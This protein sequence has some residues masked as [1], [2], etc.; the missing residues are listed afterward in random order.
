[1]EIMPFPPY[2]ATFRSRDLPLPVLFSRMHLR[3]RISADATA[4]DSVTMESGGNDAIWGMSTAGC[5]TLTQ[6]RE[7]AK[8]FMKDSIAF[9]PITKSPLNATQLSV[10]VNTG[11]IPP[12]MLMWKQNSYSL[13]AMPNPTW[14]YGKRDRQTISSV[15][16]NT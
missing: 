14:K 12:L 10:I 8:R 1:M 3:C 13:T 6:L 11:S 5:L 15:N 4:L 2:K 16:S 7:R 9:R